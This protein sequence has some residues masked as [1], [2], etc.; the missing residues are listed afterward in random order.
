MKSIL[1]IEGEVEAFDEDRSI[2][3][4]PNPD[5]LEHVTVLAVALKTFPQLVGINLSVVAATRLCFHGDGQC[6]GYTLG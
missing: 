3:V 2:S 4:W 1:I 6:E 5:G